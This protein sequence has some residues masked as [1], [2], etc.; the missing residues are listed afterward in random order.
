MASTM[1]ERYGGFAKVSRIVSSFYDKVMESPVLSP[2]FANVEMRRLVDHQTKFIASLM[3]GPVSYSN[4]HIERVHAHL[5]VTDEAFREAVDLL[6]E[7]FE[8]F[9]VDETDI[10]AVFNEIMSLKNFI[11]A[12]K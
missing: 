1:F 4:E 12:R 11:V 8:D 10:S 9:E 5:G 7:T 3:N 2:Y 6:R